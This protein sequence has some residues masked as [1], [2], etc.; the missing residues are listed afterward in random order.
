[1]KSPKHA[2]GAALRLSNTHNSQVLRLVFGVALTGLAIF[3]LI[4]PTIG[5]GVGYAS[6]ET[7][8][9]TKNARTANFAAPVPVATI[10]VAIADASP[11]VEGNPPA[12]P[13]PT[14]S[15]TPVATFVVSLSTPNPD[16][17]PVTVDYITMNGTASSGQPDYQS[18]AGTVSFDMGQQTQTISVPIIPDTAGEGDETFSV[19]LSNPQGNVPLSI[20]DDEGQATIVDD[21]SGGGIQFSS[22]NYSVN[23]GAGL[24]AIGGT[25]ARGRDRRRA[26]G[27][28]YTT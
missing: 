13:T 19:K 20:A 15:P 1:M 18:S 23:E 12:S 14:V 27:S 5:Y 25:I 4:R 8:A 6:P 17:S 3:L 9:R 24:A 28:G 10:T 7:S 2:G 21:D 16:P 11:V 26:P 22:A